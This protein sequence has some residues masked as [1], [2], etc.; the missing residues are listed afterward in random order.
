MPRLQVR[1]EMDKATKVRM[2]VSKKCLLRS[3]A[4]DGQKKVSRTCDRAFLIV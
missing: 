1:R 2:V 4:F 3:N